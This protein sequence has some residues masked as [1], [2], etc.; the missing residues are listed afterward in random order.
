MNTVM[1]FTAFRYTE[2][3]FAS[4]NEG[5]EVAITKTESKQFQLKD[6]GALWRQRIVARSC[7][8]TTR[9]SLLMKLAN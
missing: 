6:E 1:Y 9:G 4:K 7:Q 8:A 3:R 2:N 5:G